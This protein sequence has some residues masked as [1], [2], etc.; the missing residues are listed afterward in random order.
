MR[1]ESW[2]TRGCL[3]WRVWA[4]V[5]LALGLV[6]CGSGTGSG[7]PG[8]TLT[9]SSVKTFHF[10]WPDASA[11][12]EY[13]LL[14]NPDG[15]AGYTQIATLPANTTSHDLVV[16]LPG[17]L[18][19]SYILQTCSGASCTSSAPVFVSSS[20]NPAIGYLKASNTG[21][22]DQAGYSLALSADG[23]TLAVGAPY[24]DSS[25]SGINGNQ[26]DEAGQDSGAV[27]VYTRNGGSWS[28]QAYVKASN[29]GFNDGFGW[30]VALA[31]DGNT[32]AVGAP[33]EDSSATGVGGNQ[34]DNAASGSGATYVYTRS[35]GVW[36]QQAYVK[37]SNTGFDDSFGWSVALAADGNALAVGAP[38]ED[39]SATGINGN[40]ADNTAQDSGAAY[41]YTRSGGNW[42]QQAYVKASNT[43]LAD[44]FGWSM[45][46]ADD[47]STLA[48]GAPYEDSSATGIN[49]NTADNAASESGAA[50]V[51]TRSA[52]VWSQQAYVKAS[53]TGFGDQFGSS[54]A[55]GAAGDTLAVGAPFEDSSATGLNGS[56][57]DES[58]SNSGAA[59]LYTRSA[60]VWRRLAYVKA[61]N[62]GFDDGFGSNL[63][64]AADG[65]TLAAGAPLEDS[66]AT[67]IGGTQA[68]NSVGSSGAVYLY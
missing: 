60:G 7:T 48:V 39:S 58:G 1:Q 47:G 59:Y 13:R 40:A 26:A 46:L 65:N 16:F 25:A 45:A 19:A 9:P 5:V 55:L 33:G 42:S 15:V 64:L 68:D 21:Y 37:A 22:G 29:T 35:A 8:F 6:S 18:N 11:E 51:Y 27:Y 32:L 43:G 20:L 17:R 67:G 57:S 30:S 2:G 4:P 49:G 54:L 44:R 12:T 56:E 3:V 61:S 10:A 28:Q 66:G 62:T 14:E 38:Y 24:E 41:V 50:Y 63:A 53:N 23:S 31:A 36:S 34:A 52:G